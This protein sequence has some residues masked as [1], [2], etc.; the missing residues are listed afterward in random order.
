MAAPS[1]YHFYS[2]MLFCRKQRS[3]SNGSMSDV[4]DAHI[5]THAHSTHAVRTSLFFTY[6]SFFQFPS[7]IFAGLWSTENLAWRPR[8]SSGKRRRFFHRFGQ[9]SGHS[10]VTSYK[11]RARILFFMVLFSEYLGGAYRAKFSRPN[12][13]SI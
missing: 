3:A 4:N 1:V 9:P 10:D 8:S 5:H 13:L 7:F 12:S 11:E 2:R 6:R